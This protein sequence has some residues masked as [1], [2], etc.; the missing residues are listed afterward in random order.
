V[1]E[2]WSFNHSPGKRVIT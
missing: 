1:T 2:F